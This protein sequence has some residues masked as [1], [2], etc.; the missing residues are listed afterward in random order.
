[1]PV[2]VVRNLKAEKE[3]KELMQKAEIS[4]G[5]FGGTEEDGQSLADIAAKNEVDR[6]FMSRAGEQSGKDIPAFFEKEAKKPNYNAKSVFDKVGLLMVSLIK[7][8]I[9]TADSWA[10]PNS[11]YTMSLK[12]SSHPLI[13]TGTMRNNAD[14][15]VEK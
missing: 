1:M 11:A 8:E 9:D 12:K 10:K 14:Y 13:D 15:K 3:L 2:S 7:K 6:P 5:Y 4:A